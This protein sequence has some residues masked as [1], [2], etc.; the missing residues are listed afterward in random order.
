MLNGK[1]EKRVDTK[2]Q[3]ITANFWFNMNAEEA[4]EFGYPLTD[5]GEWDDDQMRV[6]GHASALWRSVATHEVLCMLC[7]VTSQR[8][9][10]V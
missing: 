2:I 1:K 3:K 6:I 10:S 5:E 9:F 8:A 4:V 7:R